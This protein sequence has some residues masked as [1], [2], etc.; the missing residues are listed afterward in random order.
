VVCRGDDE[1]SFRLRPLL[2]SLGGTGAMFTAN[3][4]RPKGKGIA[5][6]P[7]PRGPPFEFLPIPEEPVVG[8]ARLVEGIREIV[9]KASTMPVAPACRARAAP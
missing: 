7:P 9:S 3:P 6:A 8:Y 4:S 1:V 5:A 2:L